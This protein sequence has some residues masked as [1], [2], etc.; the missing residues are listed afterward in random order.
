MTDPKLFERLEPCGFFFFNKGN[1]SIIK[2]FDEIILWTYIW[3]HI[4]SEKK[5][6]KY[7]LKF[8]CAASLFKTGTI[9]FVGQLK[10]RYFI[11]VWLWNST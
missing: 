9:I 6:N 2:N 3:N 8:T 1:K 10:I 5:V 4:V 7:M 11:A